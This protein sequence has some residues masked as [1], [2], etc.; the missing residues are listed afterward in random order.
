MAAFIKHYF[1][2]PLC[3][4][5]AISAAEHIIYNEGLSEVLQWYFADGILYVLNQRGGMYDDDQRR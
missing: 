3:S 1:I 5:V 4:D 2:D